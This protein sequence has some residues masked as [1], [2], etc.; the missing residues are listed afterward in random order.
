MPIVHSQQ[1]TTIILCQ[2]TQI[3]LHESSA[4]WFW[5]RLPQDRSQVRD[6][7]HGHRGTSV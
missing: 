5:S 3:I 4:K 2:L 1:L 7:H 6:Q